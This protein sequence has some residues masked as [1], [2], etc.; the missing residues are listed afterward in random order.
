M[1]SKLY[2]KPLVV[3]SHQFLLV[4]SMPDNVLGYQVPEEYRRFLSTAVYR[5]V[6]F[7]SDK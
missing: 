6:C 5:P 1:S 2:H 3:S 4:F 7:G